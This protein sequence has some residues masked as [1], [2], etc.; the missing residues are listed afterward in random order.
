MVMAASKLLSIIIPV[1]NS[2]QYLPRTLNA[3]LQQSLPLSSLQV[4]LVNDCSTDNSQE[5]I[6]HY[7][8]S[9]VDS[10]EC[11]IKTNNGGLSQARNTGLS[12]VCGKYL[13]FLDSDDWVDN[14]LYQ[15]CI[16]HLETTPDCEFI[17]FNY[18]EEWGSHVK[19]VNCQQKIQRSKYFMPLVAWNKVFRTEFWRRYNF[20]F[21]P[22]IHYEDVELIP[23]I[24][25]YAQQPSYLNNHSYFLHYDR[26]P[27]DSITKKRR[28]TDS[29]V[30]IFTQLKNFATSKKSKQLNQFIATN[31]FYQL[32][33]FGGSPKISYQI[34][35]ANRNLFGAH[36][37]VSKLHLPLRLVQLLHVDFLLYP[38]IFA[39]DKLNI[40]ANS[41]WS[42]FKVWCSKL[43]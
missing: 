30:T 2:A 12:R 1:Y 26:T 24:I 21:L 40:N 8:T 6:N 13:A 23:Q 35:C 43:R 31:L 16:N 22:N 10:F 39:L 7:I 18:V 37:I 5:I 20:T 27:E 4:I 15:D 33:L 9:Y 38:L 41:H 28:N 14:Q 42:I 36:N 32:V 29:L 19:Q 11:I 17:S 34:Y 25:F 3:L